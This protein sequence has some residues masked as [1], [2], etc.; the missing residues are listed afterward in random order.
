MIPRHTIDTIINAARIEEVVGDFV[1][2]KRRGVNLI[3][4][5]PFH[6]EKTPSF[7]V[8]PTRGIYKCFG[9][10]KGGNAVNFIMEHEHCSYPEALRYLA[11]KYNIEVQE[12]E[13]SPEYTREQQLRESLLV[14]T[15]F[16]ARYFRDQ[17]HN[18]DEGKSVGGTYFYE[19]GFT[20]KTIETFQLGY[21][22]EGWHAFTTHALASGYQL[23]VL[24][25]AG[26][27]VVSGERRL[28]RFHGRVMFPIHNVTGKVI[29]FGARILKSDA[30]AAKYLN[31][32]ESEIYHK[33]KILYGIWHAKKAIAA[34]DECFLVE[35]YTDVISMHQSGIE[36]VVASSGTALTTDQIRLISRYTRNVTVLY[37]GDPAGIK[38]SLRGIDL[39]LAEGLNVKVVLFP[40]GHD[41]DSFA[42][43]HDIYQ[44][45]EYLKENAR[46]FIRFKTSLL[47]EG[48]ANDPIKKAGLIRD[49]M[50]TIALIPDP[51]IRSTYTK[52]CSSLMDISEQ[53]LISELN[54]IL[55]KSV[56]KAFEPETD[57]EEIP[58]EPEPEVQAAWDESTEFH[59]FDL[60][61][62]ALNYGNQIVDFP[63]EEN[64][65]NPPFS[66][67]VADFIIREVAGE[68]VVFENPVYRTIFTGLEQMMHNEVPY[69]ADPFINHDDTNV[70]LQAATML[71]MKYSLSDRWTDKGVF[72]LLEQDILHKAVTGSIYAWRT[73][74][75]N[76]MIREVRDKLKDAKDDG[77]ITNLLKE[78]IELD[79]IKK[80][81]A[82]KLGIVVLK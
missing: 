14:V 26:L 22:P 10:G 3:G 82:K 12:E 52:E 13:K 56:S 50:E 25:K 53:V 62:L 32:P 44:L 71:A 40:D 34:K 77:E 48:T 7:N 27:T 51:I 47:M 57:T 70:Q 37:D 68:P 81:I 24:E 60:L 49:I 80:E 28:D 9:C 31:S 16:A 64:P 54:K 30:K 17:L 42:K 6:N 55:K 61:R 4:L 67:K 11:S 75:I 5:C 38:A 41:P 18:T 36:N 1:N 78:Q 35:G 39:I 59:E 8:S 15:D 33:S 74:V 65:G 63:D 23:D 66:E 21:S 20:D 19:R 79:S 58:Q 69:S 45:Q 76:K 29:A 72:V 43:A 46:D 2:L 73:R